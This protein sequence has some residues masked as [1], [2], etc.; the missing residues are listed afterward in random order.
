M[1]MLALFGLALIL[2]LR[3]RGKD[4]WSGGRQHGLPIAY[5]LPDL[6]PWWEGLCA[7][8]DVGPCGPSQQICGCGHNFIPICHPPGLPHHSSPPTNPPVHSFSL[9]LSTLRDTPAA[10]FHHNTLR[11]LPLCPPSPP[12]KRGTHPQH[13]Q[14]PLKRWHHHPAHRP[15]SSPPIP[16]PPPPL[17]PPPRAQLPPPPHPDQTAWPAPPASPRQSPSRSRSRTAAQGGGGE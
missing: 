11:A 14:A 17:S 3:L 5:R 12:P 10:T 13:T 16:P 8:S 9:T 4:Q 1:F 2:L 7:A 15:R 6:R